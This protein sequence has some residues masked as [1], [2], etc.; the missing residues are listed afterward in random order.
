MRLHARGLALAI[1]RGRTRAAFV[2]VLVALTTGFGMLFRATAALAALVAL[3]TLVTLFKVALV[4][5][6][7][8]VLV[9]RHGCLLQLVVPPHH[10]GGTQNLGKR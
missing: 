2:V 8:L 6:I 3:A 4:A 9:I 10:C 7:T 5:L 1:A